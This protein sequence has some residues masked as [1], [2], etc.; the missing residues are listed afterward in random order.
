MRF[1]KD[2]PMLVWTF[3]LYG[4]L[5]QVIF[6]KDFFFSICFLFQ[7]RRFAFGCR[8]DL[9]EQFMSNISLFTVEEMLFLDKAG[10]VSKK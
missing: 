10:F 8:D 1:R 3:L 4:G 9:I 2:L 7:L 6:L 5:N